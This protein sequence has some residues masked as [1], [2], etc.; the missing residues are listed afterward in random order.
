MLFGEGFGTLAMLL[1]EGFGTMAMLIG[2]GFGTLAKERLGA[3][4][5][6]TKTLAVDKDSLRF[7]VSTR[8]TPKET[9][10]VKGV[11][12]I[13]AAAITRF[14]SCAKLCCGP[15]FR[16]RVHKYITYRLS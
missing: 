13:L 7:Q 11:I 3:A 10:W 2:K 15:I 4:A 1:G 14:V 6:L 5:T 16:Y 12:A 8:V 9:S